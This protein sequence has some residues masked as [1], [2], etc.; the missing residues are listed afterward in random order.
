MGISFAGVDLLLEDPG[1]VF[2]SWLDRNLS[3]QDMRLFGSEP[4]A[5]R[6]G[7]DGSR[8]H[9]N[10]EGVG[11]PLLNWSAPPRPKL[12]T[13]WMPTGASRWGVGLFLASDAQLTEIIEAIDEPLWWIG[14]IF[15][16]G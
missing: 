15:G 4:V 9:E 11:L 12:N 16:S 1:G 8:H 3:L 5:Y 6:E 13:L 10:R 7:R 14:D 2:Q